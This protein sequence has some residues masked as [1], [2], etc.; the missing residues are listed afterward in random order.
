MTPA[1][2]LVAADGVLRIAV[3]Q[4]YR[5]EKEALSMVYSALSTFIASFFLVAGPVGVPVNSVV[6]EGTGIDVAKVARKTAFRLLRALVGVRGY[7]SKLRDEC[8]LSLHKLAGLCKGESI[9][10]AFPGN[11]ATGEKT[12]LKKLLEAIQTA[13]DAMGAHI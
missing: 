6:S 1:E 12:M 11:G 4:G 3:V 7:R 8:G 9:V 13:A 2:R 10:N 5:Y